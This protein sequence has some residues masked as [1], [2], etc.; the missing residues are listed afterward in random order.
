M[1]RS[2]HE[3]SSTGK[4]QPIEIDCIITKVKLVNNTLDVAY[5]HVHQ[6][7]G[8]NISVMDKKDA[9]Q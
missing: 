1:K 4:I 6:K 8:H 3:K 9:G 5:K 7:I 2:S